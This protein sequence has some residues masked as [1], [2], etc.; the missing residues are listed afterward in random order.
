MNNS[1]KLNLFDKEIVKLAGWCADIGDAY[2]ILQKNGLGESHTALRIL[3][4]RLANYRGALERTRNL[5]DQ[6]L[7]EE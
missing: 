6:L 4:E 1:D 2:A 5:Y 3:R 7:K